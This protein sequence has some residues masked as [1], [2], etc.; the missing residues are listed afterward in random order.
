MNVGT[1]KITTDYSLLNTL[2]ND[3]KEFKSLEQV[4]EYLEQNVSILNNYI[5]FYQNKEVGHFDV[6][7]YDMFGIKYP[8]FKLKINKELLEL[9]FE[10]EYISPLGDEWDWKI[11]KFKESLD[12]YLF[13]EDEGYISSCEFINNTNLNLMTKQ[14]ISDYLIQNFF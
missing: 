5:L 11:Y 13:V 9:F 14:E 7:Y 4:R 3:K 8:K 12:M 2:N 10:E 1:I 6:R